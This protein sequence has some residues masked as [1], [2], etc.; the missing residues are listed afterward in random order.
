MLDR[1]PHRERMAR[2]YQ[3]G[4]G[5]LTCPELKS[6]ID[7]LEQSQGFGGQLLAL[8]SCYGSKNTSLAL[9]YWAHTSRNLRALALEILLKIGS[10]VVIAQVLQE[11]TPLEVKPAV[12]KLRLNRNQTAID[13]YV[14]QLAA[15]AGTDGLLAMCLPYAS[16]P[17]V[18]QHWPGRMEGSA[19][20]LAWQLL[21]TYHP[22][23]AAQRVMTYDDSDRAR[24][25]DYVLVPMVGRAAPLALQC[26]LSLPDQYRRMVKPGPL[27]RKFPREVVSDALQ[28]QAPLQPPYLMPEAPPAELPELMQLLQRAPGYTAVPPMADRA[29]ALEV[30]QLLRCL[31]EN[32]AT[33]HDVLRKVPVATR[34]ALVAAW[35]SAWAV[36]RTALEQLLPLQLSQYDVIKRAVQR[37]AFHMWLDALSS[38]YL[39]S[40][41]QL[42]I[43]QTCRRE[44]PEYWSAMRAPLKGQHVLHLDPPCTA[45]LL[46]KEP[47]LARAYPA[48]A[49]KLDAAQQLA[50]YRT[51]Q[52]AAATA[53]GELANTL[54]AFGD[55]CSCFRQAAAVPGTGCSLSFEASTRMAPISDKMRLAWQLV[56]APERQELLTI[57]VSNP[58]T[59]LQQDPAAAAVAEVFTDWQQW[60]GRAL[61]IFDR[62]A[63]T[64]AP[65]ASE[66]PDVFRAGLMRAAFEPWSVLL[67]KL[68]PD[69]VFQLL[70]AVTSN[71]KLPDALLASDASQEALRRLQPEQLE[72][73]L[74]VLAPWLLGKPAEMTGKLPESAQMYVVNQW[75]TRWA[76]SIAPAV[77]DLLRGVPLAEATALTRQLQLTNLD[78]FLAHGMQHLCPTAKQVL[79]EVLQYTWRPSEPLY[80][81]PE[82]QRSQLAAVLIEVKLAAEPDPKLKLDSIRPLLMFL[83]WAALREQP[84]FVALQQHKDP[85]NRVEAFH[86]MCASALVEPRNLVKVVEQLHRRAK[87]QDPVRQQLLSALRHGPQPPVQHV[88]DPSPICAAL[89]DQAAHNWAALL[90]ALRSVVDDVV[91]ASDS[92]HVSLKTLMDILSLTLIHFPGWTSACLVKVATDQASHLDNNLDIYGRCLLTRS[93]LVRVRGDLSP[94]QVKERALEILRH[95]ESIM[96]ALSE[97]QDAAYYIT[98]LLEALDGMARSAAQHAGV[99]YQEVFDP[100]MQHLTSVAVRLL[101]FATPTHT[102]LESVQCYSALLW[103]YRRVLERMPDSFLSIRAHVMSRKAI[104]ILAET[105]AEQLLRAL[106][107]LIP[108]GRLDILMT[109]LREPV[110][111]PTIVERAIGRLFKD[112]RAK[113]AEVVP[114]LV[115][116]DPSVMLLPRVLTWLHANRQ[117]LLTPILPLNALAGGTFKEGSP[118]AKR[119]RYLKAPPTMWLRTETAG[120]YYRL[121]ATQQ[122]TL[123]TTLLSVLRAARLD[124]TDAERLI[125]RIAALPAVSPSTLLSLLDTPPGEKPLPDAVKEIVIQALARTDDAQQAW[126]AL[127]GAFNTDQASAAIPAVSALLTA[128]QAR[129]RGRGGFGDILRLLQSLPWVRVSV[130]KEVIRLLGKFAVQEA[131]ALQELVLIAALPDL[132]RSARLQL[133]TSLQPYLDRPEVGPIFLD[134]AQAPDAEVAT[135]AAYVP[136]AKQRSAAAVAA[137]LRTFDALLKHPEVEVKAAAMKAWCDASPPIGLED[138][139]PITL[140]ILRTAANKTDAYMAGTAMCISNYFRKLP[141]AVVEQDGSADSD[142]AFSD[143]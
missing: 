29:H 85:S 112:Y 20:R 141:F 31:Q 77:A 130:M 124:N 64:L 47:A 4:V 11:A 100:P 10:T 25:L 73:L 105:R 92:S 27:L 5:S 34:E 126:S 119:A 30:P 50:L 113:V 21:A 46:L 139:L 99:K 106:L 12:K 120:G 93:D 101:T 127:C 135:A 75:R 35:G 67:H 65:H 72:Q 23:Y 132:H 24:R 128:W 142:M 44:A 51:V 68:S 62:V 7:S 19:D 32:V 66:A 61:P 143:I 118:T 40:R 74:P 14:G 39:P 133:L 114:Q 129:T 41:L 43:L 22:E 26:Y 76:G 9:K 56:A 97:R 131:A 138:G 37:T 6:L 1:L 60:W 48:A 95:S 71:S 104:S 57:G 89:R 115:A 109:F 123:A 83:P 28:Q 94:Q 110:Q 16:L 107:P 54:G 84:Q 59:L 81:V 140:A 82:P 125:L 87:E 18:Q 42:V 38:A 49:S 17:L 63:G 103:L 70:R 55:M 108:A 8:Q 3:I 88:P 86:L 137:V 121:T 79:Y 78:D 45:V 90:P 98:R 53:A 2:M 15:A 122:A 91:A 102:A 134:A 80:F 52:A 58:V 136:P 13:T 116:A 36:Q 117:D 69:N 111:L 33:V 96:T